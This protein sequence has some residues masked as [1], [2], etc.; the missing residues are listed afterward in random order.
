MIEA[1]VQGKTSKGTLR[2]SPK[3][4]KGVAKPGISQCRT[5]TNAKMSQRMRAQ[6]GG[7]EKPLQQVGPAISISMTPSTGPRG[8]EEAQHSGSFHRSMWQGEGEGRL[9][10]AQAAVETRW[11]PRQARAGAKG[12]E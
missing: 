2:V 9:T 11:V 5:D 12:K 10:G 3:P 1:S 6:S 7:A 8:N 4:G